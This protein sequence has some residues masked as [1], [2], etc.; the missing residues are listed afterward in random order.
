MWLFCGRGAVAEEVRSKSCLMAGAA[1]WM[2]Q[3]RQKRAK[4]FVLISKMSW[5]KFKIGYKLSFNTGQQCHQD[6]TKGSFHE[7]M[8]FYI[9]YMFLP[10]Q[11][12]MKHLRLNTIYLKM[13]WRIILFPRGSQSVSLI[14]S[15]REEVETEYIGR[16]QMCFRLCSGNSARAYLKCQ[17]TCEWLGTRIHWAMPKIEIYT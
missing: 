13:L 14:Y 7:R 3:D 15:S 6:H 5:P 11:C 10:A 12:D 9:T 1:Y 17:I 2:F 4:P 16:D 8:P